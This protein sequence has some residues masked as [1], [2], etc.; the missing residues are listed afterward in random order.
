VYGSLAHY[1][2]V[3]PDLGVHLDYEARFVA[4]MIQWEYRDPTI[5][6]I[7]PHPSDAGEVR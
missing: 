3:Q 7:A 5:Q 6:V 2:R 1:S 4:A